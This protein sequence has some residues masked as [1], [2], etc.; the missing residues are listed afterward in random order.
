MCYI[1][2]NNYFRI[3]ETWRTGCF[4]RQDVPLQKIRQIPGGTEK[5]FAHHQPTIILI[6][7]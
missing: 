6:V 3:V 1:S 4:L 2:R 5:F 7:I